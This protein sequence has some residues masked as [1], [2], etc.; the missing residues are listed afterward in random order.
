MC[1]MSRYSISTGTFTVPPGGDGFYY[2]TTYLLVEAAELGRFDIHFNGEMICNAHAQT[3]DTLNEITSSCS[4][5]VYGTEGKM[6][7]FS[8]F[9]GR[10][11]K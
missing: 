9:L 4:A 10:W 1:N 6:S 2:L 7:N 8:Y 11:F 3:Y 5:I